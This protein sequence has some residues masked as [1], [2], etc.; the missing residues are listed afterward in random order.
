MRMLQFWAGVNFVT[1][2]NLINKQFSLETFFVLGS[3]ILHGQCV[4]V[5]V[6]HINDKQ[7]VHFMDI[8]DEEQLEKTVKTQNERLKRYGLALNIGKAKTKNLNFTVKKS[9]FEENLDKSNF[10]SPNEYAKCTALHKTQDVVVNIF[11]NK[12]HLPDLIIGA[13]TVVYM[14][15][16]IIEKPT[17]VEDAVRILSMLS[18][19]THTVCTG[20][21]LM[22]AKSTA[23][24]TMIKL[25]E[26]SSSTAT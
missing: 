23:R 13:D 10:S 12:E 19:R 21:V 14:G 15:N 17:S 7:P 4:Q 26:S 22:I 3:D 2:I 16:Q 25:R 5:R 8:L 20:V 9:D 6:R 11:K 1:M 18:G 24:M